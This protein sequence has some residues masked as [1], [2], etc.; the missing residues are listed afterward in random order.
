MADISVAAATEQDGGAD[1]DGDGFQESY[2]DDDDD[3]D[4]GDDNCD[5][6]CASQKEAESTAG[7]TS[8]LPQTTFELNEITVPGFHRM[9]MRDEYFRV[10][11]PSHGRVRRVHHG[12]AAA[13]AR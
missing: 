11:R 4:D 2:D 6:G 10:E 1:V 9:W 5:G 7:R 12:D 3:D 8:P 13:A